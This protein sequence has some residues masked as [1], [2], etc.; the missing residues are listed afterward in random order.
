MTET[1]NIEKQSGIRSWIERHIGKVMMASLPIMM[2]AL[3]TWIVKIEGDLASVKTKLEDD[4][5]QW[6]ALLSMDKKLKTIEI[7]SKVNQKLMYLMTEREID[8]DLLHL[9][10]L[11]K[12]HKAEPVPEESA[13]EDEGDAP[14]VD[15]PSL[16]TIKKK[17]PRIKIPVIIPRPRSE[18]LDEFRREQMDSVK[19]MAQQKR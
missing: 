5:G 16:T 13:H 15:A 10:R 6:N 18:R 1:A 11:I 4:K 17:P 7:D 14:G 9:E 2:A 12:E 8:P 3:A 19:N